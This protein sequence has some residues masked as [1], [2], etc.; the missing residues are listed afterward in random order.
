MAAINNQTQPA[1]ETLASFIVG[2]DY[3]H[4]PHEAIEI[5]KN[6]ILDLIG[7]AVAG[8]SEPPGKILL[9]ELKES[10]G[11]PQAGVIGG[12]FRTSVT[13]ASL[14]NG[15]MAHA[16]DYD[17]ISESWTGHPSAVLVPSILAMG[18]KCHSSGKE[19]L[20]AYVV[21]FEVGA[22]LGGEIGNPHYSRGWYITSTIGSIAG[23][24]AAA[25][26][27]KLDLQKTQMALGIA[28]SLAGG[29][30]ENFWTMTKPLHA[31]NA[32]RN[33][34]LVGLVASRGF[35]AS[36]HWLMAASGFSKAF[37]ADAKNMNE[38][39]SQLGTT[40]SIISPG[41]WLKYYPAC[42]GNHSPIEAALKLRQQY[43][44]NPDDIVEVD[45]AIA[46]YLPQMLIHHHPKTGLEG[47]FSLEFA[48]SVALIDGEALL[49]QFTTERVN[50][51]DIQA[52]MSKVKYHIL[53]ELGDITDLNIPVTITITLKNGNKVS[54]TENNPTGKPTN[55]MNPEQLKK[56]FE[57]CTRIL[58]PEERTE[59]V[60]IVSKLEQQDR[61][62]RLMKLL[63]GNS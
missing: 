20:T 50:A 63:A 62:D 25:K 18:E 45:C 1:E 55:P 3:K 31:G 41:I 5:S 39:L 61:I 29:L 48:V 28:A 24:A 51:P 2:T 33:G 58:S 35:T 52:F 30:R 42:G 49:P 17:D 56:K 60:E 53:P 27:L 6:A 8:S 26:L 40:F 15:T 12:R 46:P 22:K 14:C 16:L 36:E 37:G 9:E 32:A 38:I 4:L 10:R 7:V 47:K 54:I 19:L 13:E 11:Q 23:A 34:N 21:G 44:L 59:V 43:S 57:T